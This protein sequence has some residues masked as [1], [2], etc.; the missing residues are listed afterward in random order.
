VNDD[1]AEQ[2]VLSCCYQSPLALERAAAVLT[3]AD[4][5]NPDHGRLWSVL[6]GLRTEGKPTD[7]MAVQVSLNGN[8]RLMSVHLAIVTNPAI[9][10]SVEHHASTVHGFARRREVINQAIRM[11][12]RAEDLELDS[13]SL[14]SETVNT[15]TRI[16]DLGAPDIETVSLGELMAK[17]D[18]PYDWVIPDLLER[19][20]RLV[21]TGE[22]GLGKSVFLRQLALMGAAGIHPFTREPIKPIR[23]HIIDLENTERHV[24]RQLRGMWLQAKTQGKDPSDRVAIDCRPGGIDIVKDKDLSWINR[25]LDATQPDLLVIGPLY[26]MAPRA[27]QTDDHVAPVISALDSLRARGITL[28]M[29]AHAGHATTKGDERNMRPRG[30]A[31]LMGWPE[32]GYGLRWNEVGD[33]DMV[34]W[35]G[36]RDERNWPQRIKRGGLWPWTAIDPKASDEDW[37]RTQREFA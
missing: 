33:V 11:R 22:E 16:R 14:V 3:G 2:S 9:P 19:M 28:V 35:R 37:Q 6:T 18:D 23:S 27:L 26:K 8:K 32:F 12:Q 5:A 34:A 13:Q 20:D 24:K 36:D 30:S 15:L 31:A 21:I 29:E 4:F 17:P 25:V 7:A 1:L 10:D